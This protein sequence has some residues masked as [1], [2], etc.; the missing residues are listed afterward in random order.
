MKPSANMQWE[1]P[2][3]YELVVRGELSDCFGVAFPE[4]NLHSDAGQTRI[5][6]AIVD[7]AHLYSILERLSDFGIELV[8]LNEVGEH[9]PPAGSS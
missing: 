3:Q 2:I 9:P 7:Q 4:M 1:R 6:G 5:S 8:S